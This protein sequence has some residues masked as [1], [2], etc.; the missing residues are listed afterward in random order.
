MMA[1]HSIFDR[2]QVF[3]LEKQGL[4]QAQ[5]IRRTRFTRKFVDRWF[6]ASNSGRDPTDLPR[7]GTPRKLTPPVTRTLRAMM[8]GKKGRSCR[9][10]AQLF[11]QRRHKSIR[12]SSVCV[13]AKAAGLHPFRKQRKPLLTAGQ[14]QR[15][16]DFIRL[17]AP[18]TWRQVLFTDEK[19]F[20]L[21]GKPNRRNDVIW[22]ESRDLVPCNAAVKH[23]QKLHVWGGIS[24][25][26][27]TDLY[28]FEENLDQHLYTQILSAR[29]RES[30]ACFQMA[31]GCCSRTAIRSTLPR[32]RF[33]GLSTM[34]PHSS[35]RSPG[36]PTHRT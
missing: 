16:L 31:S 7:S 3:Q 17:L 9:K 8:K 35:P 12:A 1:H 13:A 22:D 4:S 2:S 15:R 32:R 21:F 29:L 34:F 28:F 25:Y 33:G 24:Y 11:Q 30:T 18:Q 10:V 19:I 5:I 26:G 23:P 27:K 36:Q 14:R 6:H 20:T